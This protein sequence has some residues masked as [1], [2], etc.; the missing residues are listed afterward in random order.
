MEISLFHSQTDSPEQTWM[1]FKTSSQKH[2][3]N[4]K[5]KC[6]WLLCSSPT[7]FI[8]VAHRQKASLRKVIIVFIQLPSGLWLHRSWFIYRRLKKR[9]PFHLEH[10]HCLVQI[11]PYRFVWV[12]GTPVMDW[13]NVCINISSH[14]AIPLCCPIAFHSNHQLSKYIS[15]QR[16]ETC[17]LHTFHFQLSGNH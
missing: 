15:L 11:L 9:S 17:F 7:Q 4:R 5:D 3:E 13:E 2:V 12:L 8:S 14:E 6:D 10:V 16:E 1:H